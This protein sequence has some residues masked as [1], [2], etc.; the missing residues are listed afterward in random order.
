VTEAHRAAGAPLPRLEGIPPPVPKLAP[1]S[2]PEIAEFRRELE[3]PDGAPYFV[4]PGDLETSSGARVSAELLAPLARAL[5]EARLVF[6]YRNKTPRAAVEAAR[7]V[8]R[9][10]GGQVRFVSDTPRIDA[11]VAGARAVLFPVDD[12]WGK[13]DLPIVLL[14]A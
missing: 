9:L 14:E 3:L 10:P 7:L 12:L 13:V 11:L 4:Y 1:G 5:P 8:Q 6:A 2:E